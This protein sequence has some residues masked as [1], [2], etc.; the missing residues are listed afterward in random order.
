MGKIDEIIKVHQVIEEQVAVS[1][2]DGDLLYQQ[3][4]RLLKQEKKIE[5]D[6][7][8]I[9]LMTTAFLNAAIGQLYKDYTSD[10]LNAH[11]KLTHV[12]PDDATLFKKV[13]ERAKEYFANKKHFEESASKA[14]YDA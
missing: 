10:F 14:I 1:T 8:S 4:D 3:I 13:I 7:S 9:D 6:F 12:S 11:I 2:D 5:I